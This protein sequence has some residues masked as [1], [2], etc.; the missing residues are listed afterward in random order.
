MDQSIQK[1][2]ELQERMLNFAA[3]VVG[4]SEQLKHKSVADQMIRSASSVGA[5]YSEA[6]N[7]S[8]KYRAA[9]TFPSVPGTRPFHA[10]LA[11]STTCA[12][13]ASASGSVIGKSR[14]DNSR[15]PN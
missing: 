3:S 6:L 7:A 11:N 15:T 1:S 2:K 9:A 4:L 13:K 8:S 5:H 10:G 12:R 14:P